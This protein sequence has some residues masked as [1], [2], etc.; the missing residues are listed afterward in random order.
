MSVSEREENV[1][2]NWSLSTSF[3]FEPSL[4]V[5]LVADRENSN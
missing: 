4:K 3:E 2:F 5:L 1:K